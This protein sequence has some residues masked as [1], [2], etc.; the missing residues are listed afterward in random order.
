[1]SAGSAAPQQRPKK[2]SEDWWELWRQAMAIAKYRND[3]KLIHRLETAAAVGMTCYIAGEVA[4][5]AG[6]KA[7]EVGAS[8]ASNL[9]YAGSILGV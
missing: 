3:K 9:R 7:R 6:E 2:F 4:Y 5:A 1:M 8:V